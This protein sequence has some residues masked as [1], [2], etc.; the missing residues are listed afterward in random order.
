M[1][2]ILTEERNL[3]GREEA[4]VFFKAINERLVGKGYCLGRSIKAD[5]PL[6]MQIS[7]FN[8]YDGHRD[9]GFPISF[10]E[11]AVAPVGYFPTTYTVRY[12]E[13]ILPVS[14]KGHLSINSKNPASDHLSI[15]MVIRIPKAGISLGDGTLHCKDVYLKFHYYAGRLLPTLAT[16]DRCFGDIKLKLPPELQSMLRGILAVA[17]ESGVLR[18]FHKEYPFPSSTDSDCLGELRCLK[19]SR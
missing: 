19:K 7:I 14:Y 2:S 4:H 1:S 17:Q 15:D 9:Y 13:H 12:G 16:K 8:E 3:K 5:E 18:N 11:A 6:K 10:A